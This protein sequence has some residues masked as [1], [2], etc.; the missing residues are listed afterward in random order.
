[1]EIGFE[2]DTEQMSEMVQGSPSACEL[3]SNTSKS[4]QEMANIP[5]QDNDI[6]IQGR[7]L[8]MPLISPSIAL[9][10]ACPAWTEGILESARD[11]EEGNADGYT[12]EKIVLDD[13]STSLP[14]L[15]QSPDSSFLTETITLKTP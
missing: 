1:M 6:E 2:R 5:A 14:P 10:Y 11:N 3:E 7:E 15:P 4:N 8:E 12:V 13:D 9:S